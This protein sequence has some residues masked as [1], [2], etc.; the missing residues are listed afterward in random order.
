L[1]QVEA[2]GEQK[3]EVE[4]RRRRRKFRPNIELREKGQLVF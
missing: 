4:K 1:K 2:G 3:E